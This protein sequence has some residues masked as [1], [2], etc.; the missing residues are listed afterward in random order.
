MELLSDVDVLIIS[1]TA[2][3]AAY[4]HVLAWWSSSPLLRERGEAANRAGR[5][6]STA[7]R[8]A[9]TARLSW[10]G[11]REPYDVTQEGEGRVRGLDLYPPESDG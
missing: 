4:E 8:D 1:G 5:A 9:R 3:P 2:V 7:S 6:G 11:F 10:W